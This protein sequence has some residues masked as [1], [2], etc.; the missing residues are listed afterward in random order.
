MSEDAVNSPKH[1][2]SDIGFECI[3]VIR[4]TLTSEQLKGFLLGNAMK[5]I[6]RCNLKG[7]REEDLKKAKWYL[8]YYQDI[9]GYDEEGDSSYKNLEILEMVQG[10]LS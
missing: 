3:D 10:Y 8:S 4:L 1:Y 5:Y 6:W 9:Y 7:K 2:K